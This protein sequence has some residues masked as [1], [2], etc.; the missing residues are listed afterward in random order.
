MIFG[1]VTNSRSLKNNDVS[2][3]IKIYVL[4]YANILRN[5]MLKM[6]AKNIVTEHGHIAPEQAELSRLI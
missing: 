5:C 2:C 4:D 6:Q 3:G 1:M